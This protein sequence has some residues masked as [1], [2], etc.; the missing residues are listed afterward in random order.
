[1]KKQTAMLALLVVT[2]I[3]GG[4]F[5]ATKL[6]LDYGVTVGITNALRGL[7]FAVM[8]FLCFPH[9]VMSM[10]MHHIKLGAT[11]G[12]FNALGF[13]LQTVGAAHTTPSNSA[14]LTT[15][16]VVMV[17]FLAWIILRQKPKAKHFAAVAVCLAGM[18]VLSGV[19]NTSFTLNIGDV[20]TIACALAYALSI[21][22]LAKQPEDS[23]FA[24]SAFLMG[25]THF[26]GGAVYFVFAEKCYIPDIN[27][28]VAILP[29]VYLGVGSSFIA[30][31]MQVVAQ[32]H[33]NPSTACLIMMLE[34]VFG[35]IFSIMWGF[36]KF[37][38]TLLIGGSLI[39]A[40]LVI[41]EVNF[42]KPKEKIK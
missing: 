3:W 12:V 19:F 32:R 8:V 24:A 6:A 37:T 22:L 27:W 15:T 9:Q 31:T 20:Y 16:N 33:L 36:E 7:M 13:V 11:V 34:G 4:G 17:P 25:I 38:P 1:M 21:V 23:H 28:A 14:F 18:G 26:L 39:F 40:S 42:K 30:Q 41:S 2:I 35:S 5:V 10:N 29:V